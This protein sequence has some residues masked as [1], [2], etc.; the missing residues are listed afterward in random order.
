MF[1]GAL[2]FGCSNGNEGNE[3]GDVDGDRIVEE[4]SKDL[5][6]T[7]GRY[8]AEARGS[9]HDFPRTGLWRHRRAGSRRGGHLVGIWDEGAGTCA[10]L[11]QCSLA[12]RRQQFSW[13]S[14]T[15]G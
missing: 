2:G 14:P 13:S 4:S 11:C 7:G 1:F 6:K 8:L 10:V 15:R 9:R 5:L 3:Y 12:W